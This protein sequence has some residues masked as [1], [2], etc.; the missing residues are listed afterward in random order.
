MRC[1][2]ASHSS[3]RCAAGSRW[4]CRP[5]CRW[6]HLPADSGRPGKHGRLLVL[7]VVG[8]TEIHRV[9]IDTFQKKGSD[10]GHL[11]FGVTVGGGVVAVDVAEIALPVD[12]GIALREILRQT[13]QGVINRLVAMRVELTD[14]VA[15]DTGA[16]L[17]RRIGPEPHFAHR[18]DYAAMHG[19]QSVADVRKRAMH[20]GRQ[21]IGKITL[22]QRRLEVN[23]LNIVVPPDGE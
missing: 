11:G 2:A 23:R 3:W 13:N 14:H 19:L 20:D 10:L 17:E 4:P 21:G 9:L 16:L 1:S 22:F 7:L 5:Q 12:N 6:R 15:D 8:G 18:V